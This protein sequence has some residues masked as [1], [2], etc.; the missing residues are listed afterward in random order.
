MSKTGTVTWRQLEQ[1]GNAFRASAARSDLGKLLAAWRE[2]SKG[3]D[4]EDGDIYSS[5]AMVWKALCKLL[6]FRCEDNGALSYRFNDTGKAKELQNWLRQNL[7]KAYLSGEFI[8][9]VNAELCF[10]G[11]DGYIKTEKDADRVPSGLIDMILINRLML[12]MERFALKV[13]V[14]NDWQQDDWSPTVYD[15][16][17]ARVKDFFDEHY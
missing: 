3:Y 11:L 16:V 10:L 7:F 12:A 5:L 14:L 15:V 1:L 2:Y 13:D 8:F 4:V 6:E 17:V 9:V